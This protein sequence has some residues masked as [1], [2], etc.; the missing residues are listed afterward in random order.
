MTVNQKPKLK[1]KPT[2]SSKKIV[3]KPKKVYDCQ[4]ENDFDDKLYEWW[5]D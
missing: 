1:C 2:T 4:L 3:V 5:S